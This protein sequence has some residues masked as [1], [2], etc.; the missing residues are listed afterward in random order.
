ME[1][2]IPLGSRHVD[3]ESLGGCENYVHLWHSS[4]DCKSHIQRR[5]GVVPSFFE[6]AKEIVW[7]PQALE[8]VVICVDGSARAWRLREELDGA[9]VLTWSIE[10]TG[11]VFSGAVIAGTAG[12]DEINRKVLKQ[13]GANDRSSSS[14]LEGQGT[15]DVLVQLDPLEESNF[16]DTEEW[17]WEEGDEDDGDEEDQESEDEEEEEEEE[18]DDGEEE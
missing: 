12:L 3:C 7:R 13:Y 10:F 18:Q 4:S 2:S 9:A 1:T 11:F 8:F 6:S 15:P 16:S 17:Q 5:V 14:G